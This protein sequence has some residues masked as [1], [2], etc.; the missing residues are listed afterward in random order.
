MKNLL[1]SSVM[2]GHTHSNRPSL[3]CTCRRLGLRHT[4]FLLMLTLG[5]GVGVSQAEWTEGWQAALGRYYPNPNGPFLISGDAGTWI[6]G[7]TDN[8]TNTPDYEVFRSMGRQ[9]NESN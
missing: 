4:S 2:S 5:F 6:V 9:D 1:R 8:A 3:H 7:A